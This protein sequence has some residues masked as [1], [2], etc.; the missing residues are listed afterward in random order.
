M[1]VDDC[2]HTYNSD[3]MRRELYGGL[4]NAN[5]QAPKVQQLNLAN[6][7]SYLGMNIR[8]KGNKKFTISQPGYIKDIIREY[9]PTRTYRT[10]C[11]ESIFKRPVEKLDGDPL[12]MTEYLSKLIKLMFLATRTRPDILLT[13]SALS[14]K[15]RSPNNIHDMKRLDRVI[16]YLYGTQTLGLNINANKDMRLC[17]YFDASI[18]GLS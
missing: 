16:G 6:D 10:P 1:Y 2:L 8:M 13:L 7:I 17:A 18:L 15:A 3:K 12:N 14:I 11:D 4:E 9:K 5:I